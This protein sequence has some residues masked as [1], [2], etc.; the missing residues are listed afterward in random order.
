GPFI[1]LRTRPG[2]AV[3]ISKTFQ[4]LC[5]ETSTVKLGR[6]RWVSFRLW[7]RAIRGCPTLLHRKGLPLEDSLWQWVARPRISRRDF[8]TI[9]DDDR[10]EVS[11]AKQGV[12]SYGTPMRVFWSPSHFGPAPFTWA[13]SHD[14]TL[15][16]AWSKIRS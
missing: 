4:Y 10:G 2:N 8:A 16:L 12:A 3:R 5:R 9:S 13:L 14:L 11:F 7:R 6:F 1:N 15:R